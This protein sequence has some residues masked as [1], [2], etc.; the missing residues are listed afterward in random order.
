MTVLVTGSSGRLGKQLVKVFPQVLHPTRG[1]LDV[2]KKKQVADYI[3]EQEPHILI[4]TA[5]ITDV[6]YCETHRQ[7]AYDVNV[8]GTENLL[9]SCK[10]FAPQCYFVLISTACVFYGDKGNYVEKDLPY[11]KNWY[12]LTK[13]LAEMAVNHSD[14][15]HLITRTNFVAKETWPYPRAFTD[16]C[17]TYLYA[18]DVAR[19]LKQVIDQRLTG[20]VHICGNQKMSMY[21]LAK[22]T[23]PN[24]KPM[25]LADYHGA[26]LTVDM[27]L[28][29]NR[30]KPFKL[31]GSGP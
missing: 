28:N 21:E 8:L 15:K 10:V 26:P 5:A 22:L 9:S 25:T 27:S 19:A 17:G 3:A 13:L 11:P 16:R 6:N 7:S 23:T 24:I 12:A 20:T 18:E 1:E 4:H 31:G 14:L 29:S 2:T 30:I